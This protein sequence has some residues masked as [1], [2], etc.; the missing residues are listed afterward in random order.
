MPFAECAHLQQCRHC[1]LRNYARC[2]HFGAIRVI[3]EYALKRLSTYQNLNIIQSFKTRSFKKL[4][5]KIFYNR[6]K[7][8]L[9]FEYYIYYK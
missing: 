6:I 8:F 7:S 4:F 5:L 3:C 2:Y 1:F 9:F